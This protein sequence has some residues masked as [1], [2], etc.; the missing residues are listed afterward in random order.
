MPDKVLIYS[1]QI[2]ASLIPLTVRIEW[3][4]DGTIRPCLYWT[5]DGSCYEVKCIYECTKLAYLREKE[6]G[7]RFKVDAVCIETSEPYSDHKQTQD[8]VSLYFADNWFCGRNIIDE[9]Y[10][11]ASK[12]YVTVLLDVFSNCDY[13]LVYF[14]V[15]GER[16]KVEKTIGIEPHGSFSI[17]GVGMRHK[18]DVR[19]V[20][21]TDDEDPE[22]HKM[23]RRMACVYFEINKWFVSVKK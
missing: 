14:W 15:K 2:G 4:A 19:L 18:L 17:G 21:C 1:K 11:H 5:P 20:N 3:Q 23:I 6:E 16:Y 12:A 8:E 10:V 13:K 7:I 9:R 22:P